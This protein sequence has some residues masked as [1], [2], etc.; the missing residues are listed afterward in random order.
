M[1]RRRRRRGRMKMEEERCPLVLCVPGGGLFNEYFGFEEM[2]MKLITTQFTP[3]RMPVHRERERESIVL[4]SGLCFDIKRNTPPNNFVFTYFYCV[5]FFHLLA[6]FAML[7][8]L[9]LRERER[10][11]IMYSDVSV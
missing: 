4:S 2:K 11:P 10:G 8:C 6:L 7:C 3:S 5:S 1:N 9:S